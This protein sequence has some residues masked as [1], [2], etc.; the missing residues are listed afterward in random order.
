MM[1]RTPGFDASLR[2]LT[3]KFTRS[4]SVP[5]SI[6]SL[7]VC[8]PSTDGGS[9]SV[10]ELVNKVW[11]DYDGLKFPKRAFARDLGGLLGLSAITLDDERVA[12]NL[13]WPRQSSESEL[14]ELLESMPVA[15]PARNPAMAKLSR[16]LGRD[17]RRG[18][19]TRLR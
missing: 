19:S 8:Q 15:A 6:H 16:L 12:A 10:A 5:P 7:P 11:G 9:I 14:L 17:R 2:V 1:F 4:V 18:R 13:D 3:A